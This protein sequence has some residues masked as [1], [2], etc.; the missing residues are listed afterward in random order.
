VPPAAGELLADLLPDARLIV[1][2]DAGHD[3][4]VTNAAEVAAAMRAFLAGDM[5]SIEGTDPPVRARNA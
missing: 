1:I 4:A 5:P 3:V 2:P